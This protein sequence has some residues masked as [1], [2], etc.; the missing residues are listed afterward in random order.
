MEENRPRFR[1]QL[2]LFDLD[3]TLFDYASTWHAALVRT[4]SVYGPTAGLNPEEVTRRFLG[5]NDRLYGE[6]E[7]GG[8]GSR[9]PCMSR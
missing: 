6:Y 3:D 8:Y 2:I 5:V 4:F 9:P 7:R 1:G